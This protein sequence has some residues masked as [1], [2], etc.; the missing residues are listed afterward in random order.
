LVNNYL[1]LKTS[2]YWTLDTQEMRHY[3]SYQKRSLA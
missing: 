1:G 3:W 2:H